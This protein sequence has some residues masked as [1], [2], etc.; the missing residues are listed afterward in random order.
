[1]GGIEGVIKAGGIHK[2]GLYVGEIGLHNDGVHQGHERNNGVGMG[3]CQKV[4]HGK[5]G[6]E[7]IC[8]GVWSIPWWGKVII[9]GL[10]WKKI[11]G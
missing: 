8:K 7:G 3:I 9:M 11:K 10:G 6:N 4:L 5:E 1:M 2:K